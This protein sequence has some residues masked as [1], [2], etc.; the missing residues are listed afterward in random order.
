[1]T[2]AEPLCEPDLACI[3]LA[4]TAA[5]MARPALF[6]LAEEDDEVH[7]AVCVFGKHA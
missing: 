5:A 3:V 1:M 6:T 4:P 2:V 7:V